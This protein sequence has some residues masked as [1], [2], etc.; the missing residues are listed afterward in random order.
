MKIYK[1]IVFGFIIALRPHGTKHAQKGYT[2]FRVILKGIR[3]ALETRT[4]VRGANYTRLFRCNLFFL[5]YLA[6]KKSIKYFLTVKKSLAKKAFRN[7][8]FSQKVEFEKL[9]KNELGAFLV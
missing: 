3:R 7:F 1:P 4:G 6:L 8:K 2:F 9:G 5:A